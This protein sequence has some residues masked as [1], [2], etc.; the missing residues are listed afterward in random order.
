MYYN[1]Y[2]RERQLSNPDSP[3]ILQ[4]FIEGLKF[5]A[6]FLRENNIKVK[7]YRDSVNGMEVPWYLIH[8]KE[9]KIS[10]YH[11]HAFDISL[12]SVPKDYKNLVFNGFDN[13]F[14]STK[15]AYL[16]SKKMIEIG[17]KITEKVNS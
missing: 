16:T 8:L 11:L 6:S 10:F 4:S 9:Q 1:R 15:D 5:I 14:N 17:N 12:D 13:I 3:E 2:S 7:E